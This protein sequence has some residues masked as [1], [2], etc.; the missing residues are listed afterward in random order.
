MKSI[1][2]INVY[3]TAQFPCR[4]EDLID[5]K[6]KLIA[7]IYTESE[8]KKDNL[9]FGIKKAKDGSYDIVV[10]ATEINNEV[11][12]NSLKDL[13]KMTNKTYKFISEKTNEDKIIDYSKKLIK[14]DE[15]FKDKKGDY[16]FSKAKTSLEKNLVIRSWIGELIYETMV[17]KNPEV[18]KSLEKTINIE[19]REL[20]KS[21]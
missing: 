2:T 20:L 9:S 19:I 18:F 14:S 17:Y 12:R 10:D 4:W 1:K 21:K 7:T 13:E 3:P 8:A 5:N 15:R 11:V 16:N 6:K